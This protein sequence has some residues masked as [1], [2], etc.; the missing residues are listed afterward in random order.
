MTAAEHPAR[1]ER[2]MLLG[3]PVDLLSM[4]ETISRAHR[5]MAERTNLRH[6]ALNVAKLVKLRSD[7]ELARDVAEST[8][9]GIDG[10]GIVYGLRL[11]G[12]EAE[13]VS[14]CDLM[15]AL[16]EHCAQN[17]FHPYILGARQDV[18]ETAMREAQ[19]RWPGLQFAGARNGYFTAEEE[20]AIVE[21]IRASGADCL[22]VA[23]PTPRKERFL[24]RNAERLTV[25]F[26][27]GVGGSIDVLAGKV[28]RASPRWQKGGFEWLH[29]LLQEPRKMLWRYASTNTA[30]AFLLLREWISSRLTRTRSPDIG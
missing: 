1:R 12:I 30:F 7:P 9:V 21:Q 26:V 14:G 16:M 4:G 20:P 29:R 22:F 18:L 17:G 6:V 5:A 23:M 2:A 27:M 10:M 28:S 8:L 19:R 13:R 15:Y 11:Q 24:A 3:V 25:P